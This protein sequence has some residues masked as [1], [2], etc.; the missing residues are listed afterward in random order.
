MDVGA[1]WSWRRRRRG[2]IYYWGI[3]FQY[4]HQRLGNPEEV[5]AG[6]RDKLK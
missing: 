3:Q 5:A 4:P 1:S 6:A 2:M